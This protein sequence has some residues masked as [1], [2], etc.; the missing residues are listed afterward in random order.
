MEY[1]IKT[2]SI[3]FTATGS[4]GLI[5]NT[6]QFI[7][8]CRDRQLRNSAFG[9]ALLSLNIADLLASIAFCI[10]GIT[11]LVVAFMAVDK[12][13]LINFK[14]P[15]YAVIAF[16][17]T[18]SL[19]V[20]AIQRVIAVAFPLRVK[21]II[22]K[23]RCYI[24]LALVWVVSVVL[25]IFVY[26]ATALG[27]KS[28]ACISISIGAALLILY[29]VVC[30]RTMKRNI[31]DNVSEETLRRRRRSERGLL[32]YSVAITILYIVCNYP[33]SFHN[34]IDFPQPVSHISDFLF[35]INPSLDTML[36]FM[37][38]YCKRRRQREGIYPPPVVKRHTRENEL[39]T[40]VTTSLWIA[41]LFLPR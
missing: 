12:T 14:N 36:Y 33:E 21:Q 5:T 17:L 16:S 15:V 34:F 8:I 20:I 25:A 1:Q 10:R 35:S 2:Y 41:V 28:L 31:V 22:T 9:I 4:L 30:Y 7:L 38:R 6:I 24:V 27:F 3:T 11:N 13:L 19:A 23:S 39:A 18:S 37:L 32:I 26:F 40:H 29:S